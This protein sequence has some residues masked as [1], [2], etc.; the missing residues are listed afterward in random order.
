MGLPQL[1]APSPGAFEDI[2]RMAPTTRPTA[3]HEK[4][5]IAYFMALKGQRKI[6]CLTAYSAPMAHA[7]DPHCD[8][9]LV[10][11]SVAMVIYGM[12][13]TQNADLDM[14]IRHGEAVM[15]RRKSSLVVV[16]LP[17]GSYENSPPQALASA[18]KIM[19]KTGA[20]AVKLEGGTDLAPH[21]KCLVD[22][23]IPVLGHI[24]LL[25]Q[26][27]VA[28]AAFRIT[29]RSEEEANQLH[30]DANAIVEA[31]VFGIVLEGIIE[32]VAASIAIGCKVPTIGIGASTSCDGQ[33]LVTDDVLGLYDGF[34]PKFVRKFANLQ[35]DIGAA[36]ADYRAAVIDGSFP[37]KDHLFWP[38][39]T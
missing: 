23:G 3:V 8:M 20:D 10:G 2:L 19:A 13:T 24:G 38:K 11:D 12:G 33:I 39:K 31:G 18:S 1:S 17:A 32:P 36:A 6:V 35:D 34:T 9:L 21:V 14:M 29:G 22:S 27:A 30:K 28:G 37:T 16:D 26:H 5:Q 4:P 15:R 25:P 7:L